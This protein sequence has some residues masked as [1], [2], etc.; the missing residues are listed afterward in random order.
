MEEM[1]KGILSKTF[2]EFIEYEDVKSETF[3]GIF[4]HRVNT[5]MGAQS[6]AGL[7]LVGITGLRIS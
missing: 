6:G 2:N 3:H 4:I 1:I 7:R 5:A